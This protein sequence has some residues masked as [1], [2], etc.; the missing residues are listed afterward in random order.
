MAD[1]LTEVLTGRERKRAA[2][3][4]ARRAFSRRFLALAGSATDFP[5]PREPGAG[6]KGLKVDD[7]PES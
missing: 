4:G 2:P 6:P 5:Y 3:R 1:R 7:G